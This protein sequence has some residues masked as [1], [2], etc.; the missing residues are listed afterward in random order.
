ML[1]SR[2]CWHGVVADGG[3]SLFCRF[4]QIELMDG[5]VIVENP[6]K[7]GSEMHPWFNKYTCFA[8]P[9]SF[10]LLVAWPLLT[11]P[12]DIFSQ[13][14]FQA[15]LPLLHVSLLI[16]LPQ[17]SQAAAGIQSAVARVKHYPSY[18]DLRR[19]WII[20][21][22]MQLVTILILC[23]HL[24]AQGYFTFWVVLAAVWTII[25]TLVATIQPLVEARRALYRVIGN[26]L[27]LPM[28]PKPD[29]SVKPL[30]QA[31]DYEKSPVKSQKS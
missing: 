13:V 27:G 9:L 12:A 15:L 11:L 23:L 14:W 3:E 22:K 10:V 24:C 8:M 26:M 4:K 30:D 20:T 18:L 29:N 1:F 31:Q 28:G 21:R 7:G 6:D 25:A 19:I 5:V 17:S 2:L 16:D